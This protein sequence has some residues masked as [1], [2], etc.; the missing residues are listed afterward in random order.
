[1]TPE[2]EAQN[3]A[4][5][6]AYDPEAPP[7]APTPVQMNLGSMQG[8]VDQ[9]RKDLAYKSPPQVQPAQARPTPAPV[10]PP[11]QDQGPEYTPPST[12]ERVLSGLSGVGGLVK[13]IGAMR[14]AQGQRGSLG[15]AQPSIDRLSQE[16]TSEIARA[17][18]TQDQEA[19]ARRREQR[20]AYMDRQNAVDRNARRTREGFEDQFSAEAR[21]PKSVK[22]QNLRSEIR[23][24]FP[25]FA[26][27]MGANFDSMSLADFAKSPH[28]GLEKS[29]FDAMTERQ[30][31]LLQTRGSQT[32]DITDVK[33][34]QAK[35]LEGVKQAG[36][37]ELKKMP[38]V[39]L[40]GKIGGGGGGVQGPAAP[41]DTSETMNA[42]EREFGGKDKIPPTLVEQVHQA[43]A[44]PD[45]TKRANAMRAVMQNAHNQHTG[46]DK[47]GAAAAKAT[48]PA[49]EF[50]T[51]TRAIRD[52][53]NASGIDPDNYKGQDIPG[54]GRA[55][56][57]LPDSMVS[58]EGQRLRASV[59]TAV[60]GLQQ[61]MSHVR[62]SD[63]E[64]AAVARSIGAMKGGSAQNLIWGLHQLEA[65]AKGMLER[66]RTANTPSGQPAPAHA[67]GVRVKSQDGKTGT[68]QGT[69]EEARKDGFQVIE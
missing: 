36:R 24:A 62:T 15:G 6:E 50:V 12:A 10:Q 2:E 57:M 3:R 19:A 11:P 47:I 60:L 7:P 23:T 56:S 5:L 67:P 41:V 34:E 16:G 31:E 21:D 25:Q 44:I 35:E 48:E 52:A 58:A 37:V 27:Q 8:P 55:V 63:Q 66:I 49:E 59:L 65:Q 43:A 1:M 18:Q 32:R 13:S 30:R 29:K 45:T 39:S 46:Q 26:D 64:R 54:Y 14:V 22:S 9:T 42:L 68:Y 51:R 53:L 69:A 17:A 61:A 40:H 28:P 4:L 33:G 20:Q 38:S